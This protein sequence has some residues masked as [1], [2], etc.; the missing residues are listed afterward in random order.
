MGSRPGQDGAQGAARTRGRE[1]EERPFNRNVSS[2]GWQ[3]E[4][5]TSPVVEAQVSHAWDARW[6]RSRQRSRRPRAGGRAGGRDDPATPARGSTKREDKDSL[7]AGS[8]TALRRLARRRE[9]K[10]SP[11]F[12]IFPHSSTRR[13]GMSRIGK[14]RKGPFLIVPICTTP[15]GGSRDP[16]SRGPRSPRARR[17]RRAVS[18]FS[19]LVGPKAERATGRKGMVMSGRSRRCERRPCGQSPCRVRGTVPRTNENQLRR[20]RRPQGEA[21][22]CGSSACVDRR[23]QLFE[24]Q[25]VAGRDS[26]SRPSSIQLIKMA[27]RHGERRR[28]RGD[29]VPQVFDEQDPLRRAQSA[30]LRDRIEPQWLPL[31]PALTR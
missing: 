21:A 9:D 14:I 10:D 25:Q 1:R 24:R 8:R 5:L 18:A 26:E 3:C 15:P 4:R 7:T 2:C 19:P 16:G 13:G 22:A 17:P 31:S 20:H 30:D 28:L 12:L 11:E 23:F 27:L 6:V 29:A